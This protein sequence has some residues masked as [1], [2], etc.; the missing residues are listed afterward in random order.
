M[1]PLLEITD[2]SVDIRSK[3]KT[4]PVLQSVD[5]S[6]Y[7]SEILAL[8][9]E[10]GCGKSLTAL[11]ITR[12]L[13]ENI[14]AYRSGAVLYKERDILKLPQNELNEIRGKEISYI[15]QDPFTSLNPVKKIK[16]QI[17]E[18]YM[19]HVSPD[20][21]KAVEKAKYL[22]SRVGLTDLDSRL[23]SY[24][25]QFSGGM[26]QRVSIAMALMC[27]PEILIADEPTS[28]LDVTIQ[29]QLVDLLL[30]IKKENRMSILF[31][32]HDLALVSNIADRIQVMYAGQT[33][34]IST[35]EE[36]IRN[37]KHPYTADLLASIPR[38]EDSV[39]ELVP[40]EGTVPSP[41]AFP[42]GCHY[43]PRCRKRK[44]KCIQEK[45]LMRQS[46]NTRTRCF[47]YD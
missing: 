2:L 20:E 43:E 36:L 5:L 18:S 42:K 41:D 40:I 39:H 13:P 33:V 34:E 28:A 31:I 19:I 29:A 17:I 32:S 8:V 12:L 26:L 44:E 38:M 1:K 24:P 30:E 3:G 6:L 25:G 47:L 9:G 23:N 10:S 14:S 37:P 16:D 4:L 46:E 21:K 15:F 27:D 22:L 45:P 11:S 7:P 35:S